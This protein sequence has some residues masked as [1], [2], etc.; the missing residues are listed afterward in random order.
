MLT[1]ALVVESLRID[2]ILEG[3]GLVVRRISRAE[4][5][6]VSAAQARVW[7]LLEFAADS[8]SAE[9]LAQSLAGALDAP[10]W[11]ASFETEEDERVFVAFPE[12]VFRY[13]RGDETA[14]ADV[15]AYALAA[16]VPESQCDW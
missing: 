4:M 15:V 2:A 7:T 1:G 11:Y 8:E 14:H 12:K 10:G 3:V 9:E 5:S 6:D 16:G 13:T